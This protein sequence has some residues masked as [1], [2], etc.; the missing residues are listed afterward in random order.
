MEH[1]DSK[2]VVAEPETDTG[3][4]H[5]MKLLV[6]DWVVMLDIVAAVP[7]I[8]LVVAHHTV[9]VVDKVSRHRSWFQEV[10]WKATQDTIVVRVVHYTH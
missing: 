10:D 6:V 5:H 4:E 7:R 9:L 1:I 3:L 2:V 8:A